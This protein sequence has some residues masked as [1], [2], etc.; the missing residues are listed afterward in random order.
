MAKIELRPNDLL[1]AEYTD[2][3]TNEKNPIV[4]LDFYL[5]KSDEFITECRAAGVRTVEEKID[6][7]LPDVPTS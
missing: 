3:E 5:A 2:K 6:R 7:K 1:I 4:R